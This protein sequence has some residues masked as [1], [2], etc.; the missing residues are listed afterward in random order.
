MGEGPG[1]FRPQ[2]TETYFYNGEA[3]LE[4]ELAPA[5]W[6]IPDSDDWQALKEYTKDSASILKAGEWEVLKEGDTID[7]GSN[8]TGFSAYPV[9]LG[10]RKKYIS[11]TN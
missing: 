3:V 1:Y 2:S 5:G 9:D 10:S 6:K 11:K 8:L 7:S 4:G